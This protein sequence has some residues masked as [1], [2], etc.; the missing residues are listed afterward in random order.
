MPDIVIVGAGDLGGA[1][2]HG[3]ARHDVAS[4]VRLVDDAGTV[5]A[6]K[7]LDIMQAAPIERFSTQVSGST[8]LVTAAGADVVVIADRARGGEWSGE[9]G[10]MLLRRLSQIARGRV[11]ICAGASGR[12]LV[13]RSVRELGYGRRPTFGSAPHAL[14][15]ALRALVAIEAG[16]SPRDVALAVLGVPPERVVVPWEDVTIGGIAATRVLDG[17]TRRR[18]AALVEP[19]W[20]PGPLALAA[21]ATAAAAVVLGR[22][23]GLVSAFVAP[24]DAAGRRMRTAALIVRLGRSGIEEVRTPPLNAHDR[25]ALDNAMML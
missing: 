9:E 13:E 23:R 20:P 6:G 1:L 16:S 15:G 12:E 19:L 2:A 21:A 3:L 25:V 24:D 18:L 22:S 14:A 5:A 17:P 10:L 4:T 11:L 8:D 7:A